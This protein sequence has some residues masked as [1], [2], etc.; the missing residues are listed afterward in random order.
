MNDNDTTNA[1]TKTPIGVEPMAPTGGAVNVKEPGTVIPDLLGQP[2]PRE[3][4]IC[5]PKGDLSGVLLFA[6][7]GME[8][9]ELNPQGLDAVD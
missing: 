4:V 3:I 6:A 7:R 2:Q 9:I 5:D 8:S 1:P